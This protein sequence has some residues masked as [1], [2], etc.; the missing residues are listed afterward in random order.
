MMSRPHGLVSILGCSIIA[1]AALPAIRANA[2]TSTDIIV[3]SVDNYGGSGDLTNSI[4]NGD[5]FMQGMVFPGSRWTAGARYTNTAVYDTDFVDSALS[6]LG[7]D[8]TFFDR[9]GRAVAY[10]TA[11]GILDHGCSTVSC[12]SMT[13]CT[14]PNTATGP[15]VPRMP[16]VVVSAR[17]TTHAAVTWWI[18]KL[19]CSVPR[20]NLAV[21]S[22][23]RMDRSDGVRVHSPA[24]GREQARMAAPISWCSTSAMACCPPSGI[25][26]SGTPT[27]A[28][29]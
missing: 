13:Q 21:S 2:Q 15:G 3:E 25:R 17:W 14:Q 4:A 8:Q 1:A 19:W 5:G 7:A 6:P 27:P 22:T 11:H 20:T 29:S 18:D 9:G 10:L 26:H 12:T 23:I 24:T 28:C 16:E